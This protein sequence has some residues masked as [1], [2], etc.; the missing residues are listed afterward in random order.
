MQGKLMY[1]SW[2]IFRT[3]LLS[4]LAKVKS[5]QEG[6]WDEFGTFKVKYAIPL[7]AVP[8]KFTEQVQNR[9]NME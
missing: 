1:L 7:Q 2:I 3:S 4:H 6:L 9:F 8:S 5:T